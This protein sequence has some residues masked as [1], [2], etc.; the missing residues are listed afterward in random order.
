MQPNITVVIPLY[1]KQDSI[2]RAIDS[3]LKQTISAQQLIIVDDGSTDFSVAKVVDRIAYYQGLGAATH[4]K[5]VS[6]TNGGVALARN[7]GV[8][9]VSTSHVALLDAD[10]TYQQGFIET[11]TFL[12]KTY[13]Q[14]SVFITGY[15]F[16]CKGELPRVANWAKNL[17]KSEHGLLEDFF[18]LA[19]KGD[20]PITASSICMET[21]VLKK[22]GGF[23]L[24]QQMGE[25][26]WV[27]AL[28][29]LRSNIAYSSMV[30]SNYYLGAE[31]SLMETVPP[32][33]E[34]PY[35]AMLQDLLDHRLRDDSRGPSVRAFIRTHLY[36]LVRRN[37]LCGNIQVSY[38]ILQ[39]ERL[40]WWR[41]R[42]VYWRYRVC[43]TKSTFSR[44]RTSKINE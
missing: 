13:R 25:D 5:L 41:L 37:F 30:Q 11:I 10:D 33:K 29:A 6:Q 4:I 28:L 35:S 7:V 16:L 22:V 20:L 17:K 23:P 38:D 18:G 32:N 39:D 40:P 19:A 15:Q 24:G 1:N 2:I 42:S 44:K 34:L 43:L 12:I 31:N 21:N 9:N 27:W 14:A 3:V 8:E 26:Q 36:D